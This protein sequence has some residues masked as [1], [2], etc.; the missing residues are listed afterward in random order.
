M[1]SAFVA[2]YPAGKPPAEDKQVPF[3]CCFLTRGRG[4]VLPPITG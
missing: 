4:A 2:V 1:A 3:V